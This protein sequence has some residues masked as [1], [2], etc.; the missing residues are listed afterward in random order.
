MNLEETVGIGLRISLTESVEGLKRQLKE[1]GKQSGERILVGAQ[2]TGTL[3]AARKGAFEVVSVQ[4]ETQTLRPDK[5]TKWAWKA[6]ALEMG[7]QELILTVST[8]PGDGKSAP[9]SIES[10]PYR[11]TVNVTRWK[12]VTRFGKDNWQWLWATLLVPR[13][14][15]ALEASPT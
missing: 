5:P 11:I 10:Y 15:L 8:L 12:R 13:G 3:Q 6:T 4:P 14:R 2:M 7:Q 1:P 9:M